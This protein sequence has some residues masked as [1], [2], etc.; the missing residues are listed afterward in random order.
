M[1]KQTTE[2]VQTSP[3]HQTLIEALEQ[4]QADLD[5]AEKEKNEAITNREKFSQVHAEAIQAKT[6]DANQ[7]AELTALKDAVTMERKAFAVAQSIYEM[8]KYKAKKAGAIVIH[9]STFK[10]TDTPEIKA[11][12][13]EIATIRTGINERVSTLKEKK[14]ERR[15]KVEELDKEI[16]NLLCDNHNDKLK[17]TSL[18]EKIGELD[19]TQ[20]RKAPAPS[21]SASKKPGRRSRFGG[22][23]VSL[24]SEFRTGDN[25]AR[26][27]SS[28]AKTIESFREFDNNEILYEDAISRG[29]P[30]RD[31]V[32]LVEGG[33]LVVSQDD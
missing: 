1:E 11:L 18:R 23:M 20:K 3:A 10:E 6:L 12:K 26:K 15:Q 33:K 29:I 19:P 4:A 27:G 24:A 9:R 5:A 7:N 2:T 17:I 8:A 31:I 21:S 16:N 30:S 13:Q 22:K 25:P 28:A 14:E 32:T